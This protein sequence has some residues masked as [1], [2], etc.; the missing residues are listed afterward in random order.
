MYILMSV[1]KKARV[2]AVIKSNYAGVVYGSSF[3]S[4][5]RCLKML[6]LATHTAGV[7]VRC[8]SST[9]LRVRRPPADRT[10]ISKSSSRS[11]DS[12]QNRSGKDEI[13][14]ILV[15]T[16][17]LPGCSHDGGARAFIESLIFKILNVSR[18]GGRGKS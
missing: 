16:A 17:P 18:G 13:D 10:R 9:N 5:K 15:V 2:S 4:P 6:L 1:R 12:N 7:V 14:G 8:N 3:S 11:S